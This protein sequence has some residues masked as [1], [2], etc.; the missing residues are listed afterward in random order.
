MFA[1][2]LA[3]NALFNS[4]YQRVYGI[5]TQAHEL[6]KTYW[7]ED[8]SCAG[9]H[10]WRFW[11]RWPALLRQAPQLANVCDVVGKLEEEDYEGGCPFSPSAASMSSRC[12]T[13]S[14]PSDRARGSDIDVRREGGLE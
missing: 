2:V 10:K 4:T 1:L 12:K 13:I 8:H 5:Y 3:G 11:S 6:K 7:A 14:L 9:F